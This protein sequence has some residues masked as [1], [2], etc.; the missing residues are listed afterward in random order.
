MTGIRGAAHCCTA[1]GS[2]GACTSFRLQKQRNLSRPS[3]SEPARAAASTDAH[4]KQ[5]SL[6]GLVCALAGLA[7]FTVHAAT[8]DTPTKR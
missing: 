7:R 4:C 6:Q 1:Q 8:W 5:S 2:Q 3:S